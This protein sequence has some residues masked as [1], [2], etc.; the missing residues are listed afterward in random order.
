MNW[1]AVTRAA[2]RNRSPEAVDVVDPVDDVD[3][4]DDVKEELTR[5]NV[6]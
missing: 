4:V 2:A 6:W 5:E 1:V 3:N